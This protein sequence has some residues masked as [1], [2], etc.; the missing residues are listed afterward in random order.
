MATV[1]DDTSGTR[2]YEDLTNVQKASLASYIRNEANDGGD[3]DLFL[4]EIIAD[5]IARRARNHEPMDAAA[6][7][8][9]VVPITRSRLSPSTR[10]GLFHML[11]QMH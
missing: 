3:W 1:R 4:Q 2:L 6:I 9:E 11:A 10:E 7:V 5:V 8:D